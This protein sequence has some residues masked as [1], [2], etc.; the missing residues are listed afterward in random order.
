LTKVDDELYEDFL[1]TF[2]E[3]HVEALDEMKDFKS[4]AAK[5]KWRDFIAK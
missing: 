5:A 4:E 3:I 2:P 1:A